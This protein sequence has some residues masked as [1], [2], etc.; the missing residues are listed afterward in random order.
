[1]AINANVYADINASVGTT[2]STIIPSDGVGVVWVSAPDDIYVLYDASL[3]DGAA[4]P[5]NRGFRVPAGTAWPLDVT[6]PVRG[7]R[8]FVAAVTGTTTVH[9]LPLPGVRA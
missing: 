3:A 9:L 1:M 7:L 2:V 5:A 8:P 4:L 6:K